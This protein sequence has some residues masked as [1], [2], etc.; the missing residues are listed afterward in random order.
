MK[1][2]IK[3]VLDAKLHEAVFILL[4]STSKEIVYYCLGIIINLLADDEFKSAFRC[5]L[6]SSIVEIMKECQSEDFDVVTVALKA[7][8]IIIDNR[9]EN[10]DPKQ[11]SEI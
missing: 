1:Q 6:I 5:Q 4:D 8:F 3:P 9:T 2:F 7:L 11:L 10:I